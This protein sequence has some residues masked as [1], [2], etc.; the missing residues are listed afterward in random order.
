MCIKPPFLFIKSFILSLFFIAFFPILYYFCIVYKRGLKVLFLFKRE[1]DFAIRICAYLAKY[2]RKELI[3]IN[4][5]S[6]QLLITKPYTT[7][8]VY[9]LKK[10]HILGTEQGKN[11]GVF[12]DIPPSKL[13]L[14]DI[15]SSV[16]LSKTISECI[17]EK[18]F[19]PLPAPCK[20]HSFF[21][22][23]ENKL[24]NKLKRIKI[25]KFIFG[26]EDLKNNALQ[27]TKSRG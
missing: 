11:G 7:K 25:S 6:S 20:M 9:K 4:R 15:L 17:T 5:L 1:F 26:D 24:I 3:S 27:L 18:D 16:G 10:A 21:M 14:F 22:Q 23:E 19:C 13:S 8:L 2:Y 12:L